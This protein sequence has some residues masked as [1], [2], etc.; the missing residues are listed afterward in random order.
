MTPAPVIYELI[1]I[2]FHII[3]TVA[4][5]GIVQFL[6][7][8]LR[9]V[10]I[11]LHNAYVLPA[12]RLYPC[13]HLETVAFPLR[14]QITDPVIQRSIF[15]QDRSRPVR[16]TGIHT[17]NLQLRQ[18]LPPDAVKAL[19]DLAD[20]IERRDDHRYFDIVSCRIRAAGGIHFAP[21]YRPLSGI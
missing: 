1:E 8:I 14:L 21:G 7:H 17:E 13:V 10:I 4:V 5:G 12:C 3:Q 19:P 9:D 6:K 2:G 18:R 15:L 16:R 11:R 20:G